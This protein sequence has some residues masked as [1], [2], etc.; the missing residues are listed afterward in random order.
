[1]LSV[2]SITDTPSSFINSHAKD[3]LTHSNESETCRD[4]LCKERQQ[5]H[6]PHAT[7]QYKFK[8]PSTTRT[9]AEVFWIRSTWTNG[10]IQQG[11]VKN[12]RI[13]LCLANSPHHNRNKPLATHAETFAFHF[14]LLNK[15]L[16]SPNQLS[17]FAPRV[18]KVSMFSSLCK[19]VRLD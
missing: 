12:A 7:L 14:N 6:V 17:W 4:Y 9:A 11:R 2:W 19:S 1:M 5:E 8:K 10:K 3:N 15:D 13:S 18:I 16:K